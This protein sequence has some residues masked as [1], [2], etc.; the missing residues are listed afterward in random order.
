MPR[1]IFEGGTESIREDWRRLRSLR[2]T[3]PNSMPESRRL[4]FSSSLAQAEEQCKAAAAIGY[5]SRALNLYYGISQ[6]GRA[7]AAARTPDGVGLSPEVRGHG[8]NIPGLDSVKASNLFSLEVRGLGDANS[9]FGRLAQL[10]DSDP[11]VRGVPLAAVWNMIPE[12]SLDR[13]IDEFP[14]PRFVTERDLPNGV[15]GAYAFGVQATQEE[16]GA[17]GGELLATYPDLKNARLERFRAVPYGST[18]DGLRTDEAVYIAESEPCARRLRE[19]LVLM[20]AWLPGV[21]SMDPLLAWW[22]L[23][24]ALSMV[25]RYKPVEWTKIIDVNNSANAVA[26]ETVLDKALEAIPAHLLATLSSA[27]PGEDP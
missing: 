14:L 21:G 3:P 20:P 13:P 11:L 17:D 2:A 9:S 7:I 18:K 5:E 4:L 10:L 25:T 19:S 26:I 24:Y 27:H 22:V 12:V 23:L 1:R 6:A 8:L 15:A 16:M